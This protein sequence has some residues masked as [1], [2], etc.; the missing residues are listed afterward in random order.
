MP[1]LRI[2]PAMAGYPWEA[3]GLHPAN[4]PTPGLFWDANE[5]TQWLE[6]PHFDEVVRATLGSALL[7]AGADPELSMSRTSQARRLRQQIRRLISEAPHNDVL[8]GCN[9]ANYCGGADPTRPGADGKGH[10]DLHVMG[11]Q[12]RGINWMPRHLH[13]RERIAKGLAPA[14]ATTPDGEPLLEEAAGRRPLIWIPALNLE[15]LAGADPRATT[16]GM[17]WSDD[18][19]TLEVPPPVR[20]LGRLQDVREGG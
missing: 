5:P 14:R 3:A 10:R 16:R 13:N 15:A 4:F 19:S 11:P 12:G 20:A 8:Y 18:S 2:D 1:W 9:N 17:R 7:M 6:N